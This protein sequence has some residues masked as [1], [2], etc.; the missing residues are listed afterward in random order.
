MWSIGITAIEMAESQPRKNHHIRDCYVNIVE[1]SFTVCQ[2]LSFE[3]CIIGM[4][5]WHSPDQIF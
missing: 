1:I 5:L 4:D 2:L 3:K